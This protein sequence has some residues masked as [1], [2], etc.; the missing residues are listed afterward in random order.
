M[1]RT[2]IPEQDW[3]SS[4]YSQSNG[5]ECVEWAPAYASATGA[6]PVRDSKLADGPVLIFTYAAF[7]GLVTLA[8]GGDA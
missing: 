1:T 3:T 6:V 5:G 8:R 2:E 4:S 7:A